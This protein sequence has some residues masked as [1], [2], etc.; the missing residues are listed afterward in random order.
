MSK[1]PK[2]ATDQEEADFWDTHDSTQFL[3][4]TEPVEVTCPAAEETDFVAP[5]RQGH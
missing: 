3:D 5:G 4:D 1:L 2:F